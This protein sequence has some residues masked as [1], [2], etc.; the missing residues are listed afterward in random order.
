MTDIA[1][2]QKRLAAFQD[3]AVEASAQGRLLKAELKGGFVAAIS[4]EI[5]ETQLARRLT[6]SN[7][8]GSSLT[9][10]V[11]KGMISAPSRDAA[12]NVSS[13]LIE[14]C[15]SS[16]SLSVKSESLARKV[17]NSSG[18]FTF[19]D[20]P[21]NR[22]SL[23]VKNFVDNA[24]AFAHVNVDHVLESGGDAVQLIALA[25]REL[26]DVDRSAKNCAIF[27]LFRDDGA[28]LFCGRLGHEMTIIKASSDV[29]DDL[30]NTWSQI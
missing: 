26:A 8:V 10:K 14:L 2:F 13:L 23:F 17:D 20:A 6:F 22:M 3:L 16:L 4:S 29:L 28:I 21:P 12:H 1:T 30:V 25:K 15:D 18:L 19:D 9:V 24:A 5:A 7:E 11:E 27:A